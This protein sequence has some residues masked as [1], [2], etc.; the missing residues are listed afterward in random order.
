MSG[1]NSSPERF[2]KAAVI[3]DEKQVYSLSALSESLREASKSFDYFSEPLTKLVVNLPLQL[4]TLPG[5]SSERCNA[6]V[7]RAKDPVPQQGGHPKVAVRT[8]VV[9]DM[10]I[11]QL[12]Q[13]YPMMQ[14]RVYIAVNNVSGQNSGNDGRL[15][16]KCIGLGLLMMR[17]VESK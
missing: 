4:S 7:K 14:A 8:L 1:R 10:Q 12:A 13:L 15:P 2:S 17:E 11:S 5:V 9:P 3:E 6:P 16:V